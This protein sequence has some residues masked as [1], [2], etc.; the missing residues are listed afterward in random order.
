MK[1]CNWITKK[2]IK[3]GLT[4]YTQHFVFHFF[5][6]QHVPSAIC[7]Q[8]SQN[9]EET[10]EHFLLCC[11]AYHTQRRRLWSA[12][13]YQ[14]SGFLYNDN[15]NLDMILF[16]YNIMDENTHKP[17]DI[18]R[19]IAIWNCVL[20]FVIES[21]RFVDTNI[22]QVDSNKVTSHWRQSFPKTLKLQET[23]IKWPFSIK[24]PNVNLWWMMQFTKKGPVH[25]CDCTLC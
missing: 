19:Q 7:E 22:Y 21:K 9:K 5:S 3:D 8:C 24:I 11:P 4:V 12:L 6:S 10:V 16:P 23:L 14:W 17:L 18:Q 20:I 15:R 13:M 1:N 25:L 2:T